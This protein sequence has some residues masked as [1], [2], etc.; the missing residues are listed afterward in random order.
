VS[1]LRAR[2]PDCRTFT[3]VALEAGFE[4]HSCG[5][6]FTAGLVRVPAAWGKGGEAMVEAA[7]LELPFPEVA[8]VEQTTLAEQTLAL[9][10]ILPAMPLVLGGCCC[11]HVGAVEGLATRHGRLGVVWIDAH[12]DLNTPATSPSG[13][14]W[15][16]PLR[17][18]IDGG[19]VLSDDVAL[20]GARS[21]DPPEQGYIDEVGL[22][23][24]EEGVAGA[25]EGVDA[26][27]VAFDVD[28]VDPAETI[29]AFMPEPGGPSLADA[30][31]LLR[32][33]A[34]TKPLAGVGFT[35]LVA[36]RRNVDA[37]E[38]LCGALGL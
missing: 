13:N 21:L 18:L 11:A 12:G 22:A 7:R 35:G 10:A 38:R 1:R 4:C 20:V 3:A 28:A 2:C 15:G 32:R 16:M 23:L 6:A 9:A 8:T 37:I 33:V 19:A 25:L 27:Y 34:A 30:E 36:D 14:E 5:R 17:M 29:A 26:A 31:A 24:D